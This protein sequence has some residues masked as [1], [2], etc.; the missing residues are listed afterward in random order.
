MRHVNTMRSATVVGFCV[1]AGA[2]LVQAEG[3]K[4]DTKN[5]LVGSSAFLDY[6]SLK[7]GTFRKITVADLPKPY[8]T[9]SSRNNARIVARPADAWPQA[10]AGFKVDLFAS[11]LHEDI[12][13]PPGFI[14][15]F[16]SKRW[17]KHREPPCMQ[18]RWKN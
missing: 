6:R 3:Q 7:P 17:A 8:A 10:P 15:L 13:D 5:L 16:G 11:G 12:G 2:W 14:L 18:V 9:E 4:I 1:A